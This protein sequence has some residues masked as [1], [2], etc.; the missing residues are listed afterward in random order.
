MS[1]ADS[2]GGNP[3]IDAIVDRVVDRIQRAMQ[4]AE[5]PPSPVVRGTWQD[6]TAM[7]FLVDCGAE[8]VGTDGRV[9]PDAEEI[10]GK[11]DHTLLKPDATAEEVDH[12]CDEARDHSFAS[13]CVKGVWVKR[14]A[15][16]L[17]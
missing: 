8:R 5:V 4:V 3:E 15:E 6:Q 1:G 9:P 16:I 13:V 11:I 10:A 14:C 12:L 2:S 7:R 17:D